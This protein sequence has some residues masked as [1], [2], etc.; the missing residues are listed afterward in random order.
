MATA[1]KTVINNGSRNLVFVY[2]CLLLRTS[3]LGCPLCSVVVSPSP[4]I[5]L[6]YYIVLLTCNRKQKHPLVTQSRF[7]INHLVLSLLDQEAPSPR[8]GAVFLRLRLPTVL[9]FS[10]RKLFP[11]IFVS[12]T[13]LQRCLSPMSFSNFRLLRLILNL[14]KRRTF[15][16]FF[17]HDL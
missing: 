4:Q 13:S 8:Q 5:I 6:M 16:F 7:Y 2:V 11:Q 9:V 17:F 3:D 14:M 10:S 12:N 1:A 15:F